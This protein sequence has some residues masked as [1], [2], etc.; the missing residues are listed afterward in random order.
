[1]VYWRNGGV[2]AVYAITGILLSA[3]AQADNSFSCPARPGLAATIKK[4]KETQDKYS[5]FLSE[6]QAFE[7]E[8]TKD[9]KGAARVAKT[10]TVVEGVSI[11]ALAWTPLA[12]FHGTGVALGLGE[13][14]FATGVVATTNPGFTS[15]VLEPR[16]EKGVVEPNTDFDFRNKLR[17]K[18]DPAEIAELSRLTSQPGSALEQAIAARFRIGMSSILKAGKYAQKAKIDALERADN[19]KSLGDK[20]LK[21]LGWGDVTK[22]DA[23]VAESKV[24]SNIYEAAISYAAVMQQTIEQACKSTIAVATAPSRSSDAI[25]KSS[26]PGAGFKASPRARIAAAAK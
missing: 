6:E 19:P 8:L 24:R 12:I 18:T 9:R 25:R 22:F 23:L 5:R 2:F 17:F 3:Q 11:S 26:S 20:W 16:M 4:A 15:I 10:A 1:M 13:A 7:R 14:L 21:S